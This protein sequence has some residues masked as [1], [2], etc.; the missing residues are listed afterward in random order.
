MSKVSFNQQQLQ[1][2]NTL[3]KNVIVAASA[4]SGK[5]AILTERVI[6]IVIEKQVPIDK[7]LVLTFTDNA[8]AEMRYRISKKLNAL[9]LANPT[10]F[11]ANQIAK[12][13]NSD[14]STIHSFCNKIVRSYFPLI[15][16]TAQTAL[17]L[18]DVTQT[19]I[20]QE[21]ALQSVLDKHILDAPLQNYVLNHLSRAGDLEPLFEYLINLAKIIKA[22]TNISDFKRQ[23]LSYYDLNSNVITNLNSLYQY[24]FVRILLELQSLISDLNY[25]EIS[26]KKQQ[27]YQNKL[28]NLKKLI[29]NQD[30]KNISTLLKDYFDYTNFNLT[31]KTDGEYNQKIYQKINNLDDKLLKYYHSDHPIA[32]QNSHDSLSYLIDLAQEYLVTYQ[33]E[34]INIGLDFDDMEKFAYQILNE[35]ELVAKKYQSQ[36][37]YIFID[38]FQ[39]TNILQDNII[40]KIQ[41]K[42]N[43][44]RVGDIKQSIYGFRNAQPSIFHDYL[45]K[46]DQVVIKLNTNYRSSKPI[47]DLTNSLFK[48]IFNTNGFIKIFSEDDLV[49]CGNPS[50]NL[51]PEFV[52]IQEE[53]ENTNKDDN[54]LENSQNSKLKALYIANKIQELHTQGVQYHEITILERSANH[55]AILK[56]VFEELNIPLRVRVNGSFAN[57]PKVLT[58]QAI[59]NFT[60]DNKNDIALVAILRNLFAYD[61]VKLVKLAKNAS[62]YYYQKLRTFDD[63]TYQIISELTNQANKTSILRYLNLWI[64][65]ENFSKNNYTLQERFNVQEVLKIAS[66]YSTVNNHGLNLFIP[67]FNKQLNNK[68]STKTTFG[69]K[70]NV[71]K[72]ETIHAS[73]GK[74]YP[75]VFIWGNDKLSTLDLN[76]DS[77]KANIGLSF[78]PIIAPL[79]IKEPTFTSQIIKQELL[80]EL[81]E[82]ELRI[83]YVA[84]SRAKYQFY[85]V[86]A[87]SSKKYQENFNYGTINT[88]FDLLSAYCG[89]STWLLRVLGTCVPKELFKISEISELAYQKTEVVLKKYPA[90]KIPENQNQESF[91]PSFHGYNLEWEDNEGMKYGTKIHKE[92]EH[93]I[94]NKTASKYPVVN[95]LLANS[96]FKELLQKEHY[97][98][99]GYFQKSDGS[100][101]QGFIDFISFTNEEIIIIDFKTDSDTTEEKLSAL[102]H[103]QLNSYQKIIN[104]Y[105]QL[106]VVCYIYSTSLEKFIKIV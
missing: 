53:V 30:I 2:I 20:L 83:L 32:Y 66:D 87:I 29:S 105:Y 23:A 38:E 3:D 69:N 68:K 17:N 44:F 90:F 86:D 88:N 102:Y 60:I 67:Y 93:C 25:Q 65:L 18:S 36:F 95:N 79:R 56:Q 100:L 61:E 51:I 24:H 6:K 94:S 81:I 54:S 15:N 33:K 28:I 74:E 85:Y 1:A 45:K 41:R 37:E 19:Q 84:L 104:D 77:G 106:P 96:F 8:A 9:Y 39:D 7:I 91:A 21:K 59:L 11:I 62:K 48:N 55:N 76:N 35:N 89:Y 42:N 103:N 78:A 64:N 14:I 80:K 16:I 101:K 47:I 26:T 52:F 57:S 72:V 43:V 82:E 63:N 12:I 71:V 58:L 92:I 99:Y 10:E 40:K 13:N 97:C 46:D 22:A 5:T 98:E 73:K 4:G 50:K 34:K 70:D 31:K 49:N 75:Y 27:I